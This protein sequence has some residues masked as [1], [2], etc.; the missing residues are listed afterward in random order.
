MKKSPNATAPR[1]VY[2]LRCRKAKHG[3]PDG[4][5][6]MRHNKWATWANCARCGDRVWTERLKNQWERE[7]EN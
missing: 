1:D 3:G 5:L 2:H 4:A 7:Y 6:V